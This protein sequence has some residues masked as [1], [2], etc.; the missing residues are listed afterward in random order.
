[1]AL[2]DREPHVIR[3]GLN[4]QGVFSDVLNRSLPNGWR[5]HLPNEI[6]FTAEGKAFDAIGVPPE[7]RVPF[8]TPTDLQKG[9]DKALERAINELKR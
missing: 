2:M 8:F 7:V 4:T 3:I 5:F 9:Q 1:M 6:Y